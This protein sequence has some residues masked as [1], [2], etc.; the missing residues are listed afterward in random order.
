[1]AKEASRIFSTELE[2]RNL[3]GES[4]IYWVK[5][6]LTD[7][8]FLQVTPSS[9]KTWQYRYSINGKQERKKL[10]KYPQL[11]L[12]QARNAQNSYETEFVSKGITKQEIKQNQLNENAKKILFRDFAHQFAEQKIIGQI[13]NEK[14]MLAYIEKDIN[15]F[16]G[17]MTIQDIT[18][19]NIRKIIDKK[20]DQGH[21]SAANQIY[22]LLRRIFEIAVEEY[23]LIDRSPVKKT[24]LSD[25]NRK[26]P[27]ISQRALKPDEICMFYTALFQNNSAKATKLGLLLSLLILVRKSELCNAR[28]EDINFK[29]GIFHIPQPKGFDNNKYSSEAFDVYMSSQVI[30]IL[31]ELKSLA[32]ESKYILP[33]RTPDKTISRVVFNMAVNAT[34]KRLPNEFGHLTVHDLRRTAASQL[35]NLGYNSDI[36]EKCLNHKMLGIRGVYNK[37]EYEDQRRTM[38]QEWSDYIFETVPILNHFIE[39]NN[40]KKYLID[41]AD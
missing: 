39:L 25:I 31:N 33:G 36:I 24:M 1:M 34:L 32:G 30:A 12:K 41:K 4:K 7:G 18:P 28:W 40:D 11:T 23:E 5:D 37:A 3:T 17:D 29:T 19:V 8:L 35:N 2:V 10:G 27:K 16:I 6:A 38:M 15:I 21:P 26:T 9:G 13:K 22:S 20:L 14:T